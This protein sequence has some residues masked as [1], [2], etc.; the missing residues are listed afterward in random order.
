MSTEGLRISST[1][2]TPVEKW[3]RHVTETENNRVTKFINGQVVR[4][5][6]GTVLIGPP[7]YHGPALHVLELS[8]FIPDPFSIIG[9]VTE[10]V[11]TRLLAAVP[12]AAQIANIIT[13][14]LTSAAAS[15]TDPGSVVSSVEALFA[16]AV[17]VLGDINDIVQETIQDINPVATALEAHFEEPT[18]SR[19]R[20]GDYIYT[21]A[22]GILYI[23]FRQND[24]GI[25]S[26]NTIFRVP[27]E[28]D[29]VPWCAVTTFPAPDLGK[30]VEQI[31][32]VVVNLLKSLVAAVVDAALQA[33]AAGLI[34]LFNAIQEI[35]GDIADIWEAI[36]DILD[37]LNALNDL[38][39]DPDTGILKKLADQAADLAA[40][41][42]AL[43]ALTD[44]FNTIKNLVDN[45]VEISAIGE[46]GKARVVA[47]FT[48]GEGVDKTQAFTWIQSEDGYGKRSRAILFADVE[49]NVENI[50]WETI[51]YIS[52]TG[53]M[54]QAPILT[55]IGQGY[56][57]E[58]AKEGAMVLETTGICDPEN[59]GTST[60]KQVLTKEVESP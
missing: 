36:A 59:P 16:E 22:A 1:G 35:L 41:E 27:F 55:N 53:K 6:G 23:L 7:A 9:H 39:N 40:L 45:R 13:G 2:L 33:V 56:P 14:P 26:G 15:G 58:E 10:I 46:D 48:A 50:D 31:A 29:G 34:A 43:N 5:P 37:L 3:N 19:P 51:D 25:P 12:S 32:G 24:E 30:M 4:G 47:V 18:S 44:A 60:D 20:N 38:I 49:T 17:G 8:D 28:V 52:Q 42:N 11:T 54:M 21:E 57:K